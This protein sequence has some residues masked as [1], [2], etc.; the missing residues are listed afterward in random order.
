M[1]G[2]RCGRRVA[3]EA[4][5]ALGRRWNVVDAG[6]TGAVVDARVLAVRFGGVGVED[7]EAHLDIGR[8]YPTAGAA[9]SASASHYFVVHAKEGRVP[10]YRPGT[11]E[12][13]IVGELEAAAGREVSAGRPAVFGRRQRRYIDRITVC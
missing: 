11:E 12:T 9:A 5:V 7:P 13:T 10:R 6:A 8:Q 2:A 1:I 4:E 3:R